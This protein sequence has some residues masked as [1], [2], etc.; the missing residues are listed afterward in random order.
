MSTTTDQDL[1]LWQRW[2]RSKS[3]TDLEALF[4]QFNGL[5][6]QQAAKWSSVAPLVLM[7]NEAKK[8]VMESFE[9]YDPM[10]GVQLSTFVTSRL[11]KLSRTAYERQSTLKIPEHHRITFN[12]YR[13]IHAELENEEGAPPS[14]D[15]VADRMGLPVKKLRTMIGNVQRRELMESGEGP[16]FQIEHDGAELV[17]FAYHQMSTR[18][19]AIFDHRTGSHN[20]KECKSDKELMEK[21]GLTQ[22]ILSYELTKIK[23]LLDQAKNLHRS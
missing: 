6:E 23:Q 13:N 4:K 8:S 15:R 11:Q 22:G 3:M 18:Q 12:Q 10:R 1:M 14:I 21:T 9:K 2:H 7:R 20:V 5:I 19:K 17:E 16:S